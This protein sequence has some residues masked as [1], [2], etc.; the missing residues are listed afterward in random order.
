M[1]LRVTNAAQKPNTKNSFPER[2]GKAKL[3]IARIQISVRLA[4]V[5]RKY[6]DERKMTAARKAV[7]TYESASRTDRLLQNDVNANVK[8]TE[9]VSP[10]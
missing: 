5:T 3:M 7:I 10:V 9:Y 8:C 2:R 1:T 4:K 6:G